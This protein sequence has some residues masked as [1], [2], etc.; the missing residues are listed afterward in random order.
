MSTLGAK[1]LMAGKTAEGQ[2]LY[3]SPGTY[4]FVVP[5]AVTSVSALAIGA[6]GGGARSG[7]GGGAYAYGNSIKVT[8]GQTITVVVGSS[9]SG[10]NGGD[11]SFGSTVSAGGGRSGSS[12][13]GAGGTVNAGSG[14]RGGSGSTYTTIPGSSGSY[15]TTETE[16]PYYDA[17]PPTYSTAWY[18]ADDLEGTDDKAVMVWSSNGNYGPYRYGD[19]SYNAT[20]FQHSDGWTY[21]RGSYRG[22]FEGLRQPSY[23]N[24]NLHNY[25]VSRSRPKTV[26]YTNPDTYYGGN[27]GNAGTGTSVG[28]NGS[29][30]SGTN[31]STGSGSP[32]A[33]SGGNYG[34]GG[35]GSGNGSNSTGTNGAV[36]I[37]WGRGRAFPATKV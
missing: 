1:K 15:Q 19:L 37:V 6:G 12:S 26:Y 16:G 29:S 30:P 28:A 23:R 34:A 5:P 11:S 21:Y 9:P 27:G 4:S 2:A 33:S 25:E 20:S 8:P 14:N 10:G 22:V 24:T 18:Q 17:S 36:R 7:G 3:T 13:G 32:L 35:R 31:G